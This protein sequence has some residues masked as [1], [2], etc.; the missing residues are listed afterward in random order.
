M[1][2]DSVGVLGWVA[3]INKG[4]HVVDF[5]TRWIFMEPMPTP[6]QCK[7]LEIHYT[8]IY[9]QC[10]VYLIHKIVAFFCLSYNISHMNTSTKKK[11]KKSQA[12]LQFDGRTPKLLKVAEL[13]HEILRK[14]A[15]PVDIQEITSPDFQDLLDDMIA[16]LKDSSGVGIAAP[17][18][19]ESKRV[20]IIHSFPSPRYPTAPEFGPE[21]LINPKIV[22]KS[23]RKVKGWEGC[24]SFPGIRG[25]V[26]RFDA[27]EI[28]YT[29]RHGKKQKKS[30]KNFI[31]R[32]FQHEYDHLE[33]IVFL[34]RIKGKD[35]ITEKEF[36]KL[37]SVTPVTPKV[38]LKFVA[39]KKKSKK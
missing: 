25:F 7:E 20:M 6:T 14:K 35:I 10:Q 9:R 33:G 12:H 29:D 30:F 16:T 23:S 28:E 38:S 24:L 3:W 2:L 21:A 19:Y 13:G 4:L 22:K 31:A 27:V 15:I 8:T 36:L 37:M 34:D 18:I 17:Q 1:D 5:C 32:I 11:S 39:G 26:P